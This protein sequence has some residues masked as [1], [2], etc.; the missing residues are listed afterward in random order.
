MISPT[1]YQ[2]FSSNLGDIYGCGVL[3]TSQI[4][5][6]STNLSDTNT[7]QDNIAAFAPDIL[8]CANN[9]SAQQ[10]I[11]STQILKAMVSLQS[12]ITTEYGSVN[13]FLT[14]NNMTVTQNFATFSNIVGYAISSNLIV[15]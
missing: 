3:A 4:V 6:M 11:P 14:E 12:L 10:Q 1:A 7:S 15:G 8:L 2:I 9:L 5:A 13:T